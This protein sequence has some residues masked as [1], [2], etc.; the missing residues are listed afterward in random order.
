MKSLKQVDPLLIVVLFAFIVV[1]FIAGVVAGNQTVRND[2]VEHGAGEFITTN[3]MLKF[4]WK[5][6]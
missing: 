1:G 5:N 3:G 4:Q 6:R 2:A